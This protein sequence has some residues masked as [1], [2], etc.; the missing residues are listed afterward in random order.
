MR[1]EGKQEDVLRINVY[2]DVVWKKD[3]HK[4]PV[5]IGM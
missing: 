5:S 3:Q 2:M 4:P 1:T